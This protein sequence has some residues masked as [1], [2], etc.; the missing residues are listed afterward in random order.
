M[1]PRPLPA[2]AALVG[3]APVETLWRE[4]GYMLLVYATAAEITALRPDFKALAAADP[5]NVLY[6]ATAP[7]AS[8][9]VVS[10]VFAPG[11]GIDEDPVTG[12]AHCLLTPYWTRRLGRPSFTA[13]QA[14]ARGG[15]VG[16]RLAGGRA[17]LSGA[18]V[19]VI[20]GVFSL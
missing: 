7:G 10:R 15:H 2:L 5:A 16:C 19:T 20:E 3:G 4:G 12:S 1:Q 17:V 6:I 13:Y 14:S 8:I 9:D 11:A 18:C